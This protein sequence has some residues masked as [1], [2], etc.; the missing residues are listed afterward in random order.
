AEETS[1]TMGA[2]AARAA[3][4]SAGLEGAA[5]DLVVTG[6]CTPDGMFPAVSARIQ[7]AVGAT[8][9]S[10]FDVNA[11]C[12]G[13]LTALSTASQFIAAGTAERALVIGAETMSRFVDWTDRATCV[14][15]GDG[16]G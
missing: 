8:R 5:I 3:L 13:F 14:L 1:S 4:A 2:Q 16:A 7:D 15:F 11:A 10:A 9:A 6:T 12:S